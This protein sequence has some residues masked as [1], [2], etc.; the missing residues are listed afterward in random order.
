MIIC[1]SLA[2]KKKIS[3]GEETLI[4]ANPS[5]CPIGWLARDLDESATA[6]ASCRARWHEKWL[7]LPLII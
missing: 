3:L 1:V 5:H 7:P 4:R 6:L 2:A